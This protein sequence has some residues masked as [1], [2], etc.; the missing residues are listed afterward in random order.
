M[1]YHFPE[2]R[3]VAQI[4]ACLWLGFE[5]IFYFIVT[6]DWKSGIDRLTT[7]P[8]PRMD[9]E[10]LIANVFNDVEILQDYNVTKFL[11]G[12]FLGSSLSD[13]KEGKWLSRG[14][15]LPTVIFSIQ[16]KKPTPRQRCRVFGVGHV[17]H[18]SEWSYEEPESSSGPGSQGA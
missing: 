6:N 13:V 1:I 9:P 7:A 18:A 5:I 12:W 11:E 17:Q 8:C 3:E 10:T 4:A 16:I 2:A 14:P 15:Y